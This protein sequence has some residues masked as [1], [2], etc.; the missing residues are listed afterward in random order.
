MPAPI[1]ATPNT[2][3]PSTTAGRR[4]TSRP[5]C[6]T[7]CSHNR[8]RNARDDHLDVSEVELPPAKLNSA[9]KMPSKDKPSLPRARNTRLLTI[10]FQLMSIIVPVFLVV[11]GFVALSDPQASGTPLKWRSSILRAQNT[12]AHTNKDN[13]H[14]LL[15]TPLPRRNLI[16]FSRCVL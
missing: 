10:Q 13:H 4:R 16:C 8:C 12:I 1:R 2:R 3:I 11:I 6:R 14:I 5:S 15:L 9:K 7:G